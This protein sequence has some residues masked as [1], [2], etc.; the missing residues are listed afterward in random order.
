MNWMLVI[1]L[2]SPSGK[3]IDKIAVPQ[4]SEAVCIAAKRDLQ[5]TET[6]RPIGVCVTKDHWT[7]QKI[8]PGVYLD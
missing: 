1:M 3:Y 2:M 5:G 7:G 6:M 4:P 8:M